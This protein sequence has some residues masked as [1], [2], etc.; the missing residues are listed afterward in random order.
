M[1]VALQVGLFRMLR[2]RG[3]GRRFWVGFEVTGLALLLI[4]LTCHQAL[5]FTQ[6]IVPWTYRFFDVIDGMM[7]H[8]PYGV[9]AFYR[10]YLFINMRGH[11]YLRNHRGPGGFVRNTDVDA[12]P[13]RCYS[14][15][16]PCGFQILECQP[17]NLTYPH[18]RRSRVQSR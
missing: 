16:V 8:L 9:F 10:S 5:F 4:Y 11:E 18:H 13:G 1:V 7:A 3:C 14:G 15:G 2:H 17:W 12:Y 6:M